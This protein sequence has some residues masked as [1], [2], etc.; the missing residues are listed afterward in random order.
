MHAKPRSDCGTDSSSSAP[1]LTSRHQQDVSNVPSI[2]GAHPFDPPQS[3]QLGWGCGRLCSGGGV[4]VGA[5]RAAP[6]PSAPRRRGAT[7]WG[8]SGCCKGVPDDDL[9]SRARCPLSSALSRFTVLFGMGRGGANSLWSSGMTCCR[10]ARGLRS[11]CMLRPETTCCATNSEAQSKKYSV[12][13]RLGFDAL[14]DHLCLHIGVAMA[15]SIGSSPLL[16]SNSILAF[17]ARAVL[18][19]SP[20]QTGRPYACVS[21]IRWCVCVEVCAFA[22]VLQSY[23]VK[24]HGQLVLVSS[25]HYCASTPSLSTSW[26]RTT[27]QGSQAPGEISSSGKFPA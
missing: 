23:R 20:T 19:C 11:A 4:V 16:P 7:V 26:S 8:R 24:P 15:L 22:A 13:N 2:A 1:N 17:A 14:G 12:S 25:T 3:G 18:E 21:C 5:A 10:S 6:K 27:L 9:L